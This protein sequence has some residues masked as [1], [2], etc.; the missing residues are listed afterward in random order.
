MSYHTQD[1]YTI[2]K[3]HY[4]LTYLMVIKTS[5][6]LIL[7]ILLFFISY[8]YKEQLWDQITTYIFFPIV[9][10][11]FNYAIFRLILSFIEYFNYLFIIKD[12]QIYIINCSLLLRD[13]IEVI[14][15]FKIIKVDAFSRWLFSN[16]MWFWTI[17]IELQSREIRSFRF[18]PKPYKLIK[19]LEEQRDFILLDRKKKYITVSEETQKE[20]K[21]IKV[22][23]KEKV[24]WILQ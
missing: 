2:I 5:L 4:I 12:D 9:F 3:K 16:I 22:N 24:W 1:W 17:V 6:I 15:S 13:D 23:T 8:I 7:A 18:M 21:P 10:V 19:I 20:L 14:D 11:L